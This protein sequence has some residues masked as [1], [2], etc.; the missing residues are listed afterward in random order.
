M[1]V[2]CLEGEAGKREEE[3]RRGRAEAGF[4]IR[5]FIQCTGRLTRDIVLVPG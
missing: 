2:L 5:Q 1:N 3:R 4:L